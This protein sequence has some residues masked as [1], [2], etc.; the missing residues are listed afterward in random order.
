LPL[1]WK[2]R[3]GWTKYALR[4][5]MSQQLPEQV[6]WH[7]RKRGF[8]V[9]ERRWVEAAR[10]QIAHWLSDLP[11]SSPVRT[12]ELLARIDGGES[13]PLWLWRCLSAALWLRFSAVRV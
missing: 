10:P 4:L 5:A 1:N 12:P 7:R 9:P 11:L 3:D 6:V 8:E 2:V 13:G